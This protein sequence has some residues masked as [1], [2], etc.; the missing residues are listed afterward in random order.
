MSTAWIVV[1]A[2]AVFVDVVVVFA[3]VAADEFDESSSC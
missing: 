2:V 1:F 3:V